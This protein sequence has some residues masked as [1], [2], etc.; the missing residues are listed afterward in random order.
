MGRPHAK[1]AGWA[2]GDVRG[3]Y[4]LDDLKRTLFYD[5]VLRPQ[6]VGHNGM[7]ALTKK[8]DFH[9]AFNLCR[10]LRQGPLEST[11]QRLL[12]WLAPHLRRSATLGLHI[13]GYASIRNA[14]FDVLERFSDGV[15]IL[16]SNASILFAN[17]TARA[18]ESQG[19]VRLRQPITTSSPAHSQ[20]LAELIRLTLSGAP[21][22]AMSIPRNA[23]GQLL[24]IL[25]SSV[26]SKD[27]GRLS[28]AGLKSAA[29]VLFIID[30]SNRSSIPLSQIMDAFSLTQAEARV[31]IATSSGNNVVETA[32]L[33]NLSPNTI[34]THLRH[35]F[36][37][38]ATAGQTELSGLI[39]S[40]G[41]VRL[42]GNEG[43]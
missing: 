18:L 23:D 7:M 27:I 15:V 17:S 43:E 2:T 8:K 19:V 28:D 1:P 13:D 12:D 22:G 4:P 32:R 26:R 37:K 40:V 5:E 34:K 30:S 9:A 29:A 3:S 33:L 14:A 38:T 25:L 42:R 31:A 10:T 11:E 39:A 16:D 20:R 35:I 24:T 41:S 36:V 6:D 21:G